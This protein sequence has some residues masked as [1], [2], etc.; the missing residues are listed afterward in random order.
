MKQLEIVVRRNFHLAEN[1][2][3]NPF[4]RQLYWT[5]IPAGK[6]YSFSPLRK[7]IKKFDIGKMVGGFTFQADGSLLLFTAGPG[8]SLWK[9]GKRLPIIENIPGEQNSRFNDVIADPVGRVFC[10]TISFFG[11]PGNLYLLETDGKLI[12]ILKGLGCSNGMAFSPDG[13]FFYLTDSRK[14]TI[15]RFNYDADTGKISAGCP[16][17]E[18]SPEEGVPDGLTVDAEGFLWSARYNG[19]CV[20]RYSCS[21][22]ERE[23]ISLPVKRVTSVTFGGEEYRDLY[24]TT[25]KGDKNSRRKD[26]FLF[27]II[28]AGR[29]LPEFLSRIGIR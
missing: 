14:G 8:I 27:R 29:G 7:K 22:K 26:G 10:G 4:D 1:P 9:E 25:A 28:R 17:I 18:I 19:A 12:N 15:F 2:L 3:W 13:K 5:D 11:H 6:L 16:L 21:G 20:V 23:R 24:I